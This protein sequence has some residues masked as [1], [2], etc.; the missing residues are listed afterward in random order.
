MK[1][2]RTLNVIAL[3]LVAVCFA[4]SVWRVWQ[5]TARDA[6]GDEV[7]IRFAHA[8]LEPGLRE[9]FDAVAREYMALHPGVTVKQ[10]AIPR[11]AW[12]SSCCRS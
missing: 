12:A 7:V 4:L 1:K 2:G 8:Q 9:A 6:G 10:I 3:A 11:R 5:H